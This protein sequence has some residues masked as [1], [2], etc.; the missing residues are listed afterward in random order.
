MID[1]KDACYDFHLYV[2]YTLQIV[3]AM[4]TS[5]QVEYFMGR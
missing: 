1:Q 4:Y 5:V 2:Q 3:Y